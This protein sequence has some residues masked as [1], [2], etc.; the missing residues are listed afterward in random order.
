MTTKDT[1]LPAMVGTRRN[2][3]LTS[4]ADAENVVLVGDRI[5]PAEPEGSGSSGDSEGKG[6]GRRVANQRYAAF[7][8]HYNE[9]SYLEDHDKK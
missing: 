3:T 4:L 5:E 9:D 6:K 8:R 1:N 2:G 7:W